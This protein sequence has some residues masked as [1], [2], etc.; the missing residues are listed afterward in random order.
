MYTKVFVKNAINMAL[1]KNGEFGLLSNDNVLTLDSIA[2]AHVVCNEH[3]LEI[4]EVTDS[5]F[6]KK[7]V[8]ENQVWLVELTV[9][10]ESDYEVVV[11]EDSLS[12]KELIAKLTTIDQNAIT[13]V[14]SIT[15][16]KMTNEIFIN[17]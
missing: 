4:V 9:Y 12:V 6:Y 11:D 17:E 16:N 5:Q 8:D 15:I 14:S 13:N 7:D 2:E 1:H 10:Q 3:N